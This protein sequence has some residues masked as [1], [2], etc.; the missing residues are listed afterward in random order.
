LEPGELVGRRL[1]TRGLERKLGSSEPLF[2]LQV[3]A[4]V[5]SRVPGRSQAQL[6]ALVSCFDAFAAENHLRVA[7]QPLAGLAFLGSDL[8]LRRRRFDRRLET[9]LFRPARESVVTASEI[10]SPVANP[11]QAIP[12]IAPTVCP[13]PTA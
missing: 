8:P 9:G 5:R 2:R 12:T 4:R 11:A 6:E 7:G 10:A 13:L 3:L 1:E